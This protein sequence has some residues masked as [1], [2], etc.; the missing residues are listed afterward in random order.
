MTRSTSLSAIALSVAG[1]GMAGCGCQY[2]TSAAQPASFGPNGG[3]GSFTV[4]TSKPSCKW[5]ADEDSTAEDFV[6]VAGGTVTGTGSMN[7]TV[8]SAQQAPNPSLPRAGNIQV[9]EDGSSSTAKAT[10]KVSQNP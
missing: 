7:F 5:N 4:T 2:T 9:F 6:K 8:Y 3:S 1:L 10:V